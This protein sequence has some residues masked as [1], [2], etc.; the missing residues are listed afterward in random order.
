VFAAGYPI[1]LL[2][3]ILLYFASINRIFRG[4]S[5]SAFHPFNILGFFLVIITVDFS[6]LYLR[7]IDGDEI[8]FLTYTI[9][10][11]EEVENGFL[12]FVL[13]A[14]SASSA[15]TFSSYSITKK[16]IRHRHRHR[17]HQ[18]ATDKLAAL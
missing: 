4:A 9:R 7:I 16:K 15:V 3:V 12:Y 14:I 17:H 11:P 13:C 8:R 18:H 1:V 2:S 6:A 10:H 5:K